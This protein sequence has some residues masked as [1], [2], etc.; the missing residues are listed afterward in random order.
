MAAVTLVAATGC[1]EDWEDAFSKNVVAPEMVSNG[2]ILLTKNTMSEQINWAWSAARFMDGQVTYSLFVQYDDATPVQIGE[3]T[4]SL[5][6]TM[7]KTEFRSLMKSISGVPEN[8]SFNVS[9]YVVADDGTQQCQ[10]ANQDVTVYA[11]GDAVSPVLTAESQSI[12]LDVTKPTDEIVLASWTEARLTYNEAITY[13]VYLSYKGGKKVEV[14]SGLTDTSVSTTVDELNEMVVQAGAPEAV[15][16]DITLQ[17]FAYSDTYPNGVPSDEVTINIKSYIATYPDCMYLPGNYQGWDPASAPTLQQ[18]TTTKGLYAGFV[19]LTTS[20]GSDVQFKFS[21]VPDWKD[22]FG[23]N[24]VTVSTNLGFAVVTATTNGS[25]NITA[26]SGFY[27][28]TLNKKLNTLEM[29][30]IKSLGM[31]GGFNSWASDLDMTY[32]AADHTFSGVGTF[33]NGDEYKFR[34]NGDWTYSIGDQNILM[35]GGGN[36]KF[37]KAS[38]EY[39]VILNVNVHPYTVT[40][41]STAMPTEQYIYIPGNQQ[42]WTPAD[43]AALAI[44]ADNGIYTG[45]SYL[46]GDFKFTKAR[47]WTDG[48]YNSGD[49]QTYVGG[50]AASTT[51]TNMTQPTAGFYQIVA[52]VMN[53]TLTTTLINSW[54]LIGTATAGGWNDDTD[55]TWDATNQVWTIT[56]QLSAGEY[57]FRANDAWDINLG[58]TNDNLTENGANLVIS[59]AGTYTITLH[60]SRIDSNNIYCTV[61][62]K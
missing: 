25:A 59:E 1:Q 51:G 61:T 14:A 38:G 34:A 9:F 16:A 62:K 22:D 28:I 36:L 30:Q 46:N 44:N 43:A 56:T 7:P 35:N 42:N 39:K 18:S 53:A 27:H 37:E 13:N 33:S 32:N 50:C 29:V 2:S 15:A 23:G 17:V 6:T 26:P 57:K 11:Y 21:P 40:F 49:F 47:N 19:D 31:I 10:S 12:V 5:L 52:D 3:S 58:G 60:A 48:E 8:D 41:L 24:D 55:M 54:G 4:K 20:D 45:Y